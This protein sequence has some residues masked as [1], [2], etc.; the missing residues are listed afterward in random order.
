MRGCTYPGGP[1]RKIVHNV[2]YDELCRGAISEASR[3]AYQQIMAAEAE[4]KGCDG[5]I[6][7]CTEIGLLISQNDTALPVFD[8]TAL[9][10]QRAVDFICADH[11][12]R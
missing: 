10:C 3:T 4:E 6:L 8:T 9:H 11:T 12:T 7:G 1:R 5:V 2:I